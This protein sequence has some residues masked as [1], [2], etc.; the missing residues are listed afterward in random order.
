MRKNILT[1]LVLSVLVLFSAFQVIAVSESPEVMYSEADFRS[2]FDKVKRQLNDGLADSLDDFESELFASVF[3]KTWAIHEY[4]DAT[5]EQYDLAFKAL[6]YSDIFLGLATELKDPSDRDP[7][8]LFLISWQ[9]LDEEYYDLLRET[10]DATAEEIAGIAAIREDIERI[11][12][13]PSSYTSAGRETVLQAAYEENYA[14]TA[15]RAKAYADQLPDYETLFP[16]ASDSPFS[17]D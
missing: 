1:T 8:T 4:E 9:A 14:A 7:E 11:A 6:F 15:I 3:L 13:N 2:L 17:F 16:D 12:D 10:L 5:D